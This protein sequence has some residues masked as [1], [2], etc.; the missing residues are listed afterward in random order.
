MAGPGEAA[1]SKRMLANRND[2][3][4]IGHVFLQVIIG[5]GHV[6][7][8]ETQSKLY[9]YIQGPCRMDA[10]RKCSYGLAAGAGYLVKLQLRAS[11]TV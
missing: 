11:P 9:N 2:A 1:I 6:T 4:L 10:H 8:H 7:V 3:L 5:D